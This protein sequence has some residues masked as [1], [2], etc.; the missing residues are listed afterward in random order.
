MFARV[1]SLPGKHQQYLY[2]TDKLTMIHFATPLP[3]F[4]HAPK[5]AE[6]SEWGGQ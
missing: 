1:I 3:Q 5:G 2:G 4:F 6:R